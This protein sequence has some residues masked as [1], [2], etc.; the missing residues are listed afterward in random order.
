MWDRISE[1]DNPIAKAHEIMQ[2]R[3]GVNARQAIKKLSSTVA[4]LISAEQP[5]ESS[6][7]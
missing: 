4:A 5:A 7:S 2:S 1:S 3:I 6:A